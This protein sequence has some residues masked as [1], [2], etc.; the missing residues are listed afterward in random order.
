MSFEH[1]I[2]G[3][4]C[5]IEVD[6]VFVQ[7]PLG[8]SADSDQDCYGYS[9]V[10]FTVRDRKGYVAPWLRRKMTMEEGMEIEARI[11]EQA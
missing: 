8:P 2:A 5:L 3:I 7:R 6:S 1:R 9:E 4:P 10:E 11:L